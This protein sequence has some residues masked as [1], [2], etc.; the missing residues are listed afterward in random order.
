MNENDSIKN[1]TDPVDPV[2]PQGNQ[3]PDDLAEYKNAEG[4]FD[5]DKIRKLAEDKK[6]F[7]SQI[8][9]LRQ[10]PQKVEEYGK[11]FALDSKFDEFITNEENKKKIDTVFEKLDK[12]SLEK[13]IGVE[14]NHDI[15][16]FVLDQLVESK[17]IDLTTE[18]ER[19]AADQK[20]IAE[21]NAKVQE[22]IGEVSD[23][24]AWNEALFGW[25]KDFCNSEAEFQMHKKLVERNSVWALSLNKVRHA[26]MGNRIPVAVSEPKYNEAEWNRAFVKAS[27]EEQDKMLEERAKMMIKNRK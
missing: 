14:R 24:N 9:K 3:Q 7:R 26:M 21:R 20:A 11:D 18:A 2:N 17:A 6:Y 8:S 19:T 13:G 12:L 10:V 25:L 27:R 16:R 1:P 5:A 23:I 15:R 4:Q 22:V